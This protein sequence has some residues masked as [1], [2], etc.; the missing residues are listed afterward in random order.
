M[1]RTS[2]GGDDPHEDLA[3]FGYKLNMKVIFNVK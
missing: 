1:A 3:K 2:N